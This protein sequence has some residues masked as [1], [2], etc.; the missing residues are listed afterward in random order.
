MRAKDGAK[1]G[2]TFTES[3]RRAQIVRSAIEVIAEQGYAAATFARIAEH[4]GLS[5][6]G[7]ISYHF[8]GKDDLMREV[9]AEAIA[10][11]DRY[12]SPRME[13]AKGY[14]EIMRVRLACNMDLVRAHP[15]H[16]R[17][18]VQVLGNARTIATPS[19]IDDRLEEFTKH[20]RAGQAAG[21]FGKFNPHAMALAAVGAIDATVNR[22]C[23]DPTLD[24][25]EYGRQLADTFTLATRP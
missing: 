8:K 24:A 16:V 12:M 1:D 2:R 7:M 5:S 11:A 18:L 6:T 14:V 15:E 10:V 17:A 20:L 19:E 13:A 21:E 3:A 25:E 22:L 23:A 4:A 9:V